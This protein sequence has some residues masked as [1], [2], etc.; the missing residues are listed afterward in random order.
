MLG[1]R[2][3]KVAG[4]VGSL[5]MADVGITWS[6]EWSFEPALSTRG[7]YN[8]NLTLTPLQHDAVWGYWITPDLKVQG[9]IERFEL[10]TGA[11]A[12]FVSYFGDKNVSFTN[13]NFPITSRYRTERDVFGL[14][15]SYVRDNTLLGELQQ[16]GVVLGFTQR[17]LLTVNPTWTRTLTEK[18][19]FLAGY[20]YNHA[21]Y[22]DGVRF[23]LFDYEAHAGNAG[24]SFNLTERDQVQ[25]IAQYV[26]F[27]VPQGNLR[28]NYYGL[29]LSETH[30]FSESLNATISGGFRT[31]RSTFSA[32]P[33][34]TTDQTTV[35]LFS[36]SIEKKFEGGFVRVGASREITPSGVGLLLQG[37][38]GSFYVEKDFTERLTGSF[39]ANIY[40]VQSIVTE[41][42]VRA[43]P[44]SQY[45]RL[46]PRLQ[47]RFTE[48]WTLE[49]S[50]S[51]AN[52]QIETAPQTQR[53]SANATYLMLT[54]RPPKLSVS[55]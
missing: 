26:D 54:F 38:R 37:D 30:S 6:A 3:I 55:R 17:N 27:T 12:N 46:E 9:A 19:S 51:Y 52:R 48:Q 20:Q 39:T 16:T 10:K 14:D 29:Q 11:T 1:S 18:L 15:G 4:L 31:I 44:D 50:Y 42:S 53:A 25:G 41:E 47:Y 28:S 33:S 40:W 49:G 32:G 45:Y 8:S 7:E 35:G 21:T 13:L 5:I 36:A 23:G 24:L 22:E 34:T 43:F 2:W